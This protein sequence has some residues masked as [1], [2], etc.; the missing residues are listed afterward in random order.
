MKYFKFLNNNGTSNFF[1]VSL[2]IFLLV[3]NLIII[4]GCSMLKSDV[5][6]SESKIDIDN[7]EASGEQ[8]DGEKD[9][10]KED[11]DTGEVDDKDKT[12][13][14]SK[15]SSEATNELIVKVY[16]ADSQGEY[17][18]PEQRTINVLDVTDGSNKYIDALNE[19]IKIPEN[20]SLIRLVPETTVVNNVS[21]NNSL[22]IVDLSKTLLTD[23]FVS[24]TVDIL[25]LYSIVNTLTEFTEVHAIILLIDGEK[26]DIFGQLDV[27]DPI[28]RDETKI[29]P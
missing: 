27:K 7:T 4:S 9:V 24:D 16:Y 5:G 17:L 11:I 19:L 13:N 29:K 23:R 10:D 1:S 28:Y 14:V 8:S 26:I 15:A 20:N 21:L 22:A 25:L 6:M 18:V 2:V 12:S 3:I